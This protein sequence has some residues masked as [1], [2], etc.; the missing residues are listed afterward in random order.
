MADWSKLAGRVPAALG[1]VE[2]GLLRQQALGGV[3]Y[4]QAAGKESARVSGAIKQQ[5]QQIEALQLRYEQAATIA[6]DAN[7]ASLKS[8][9]SYNEKGEMISGSA[10]F[11]M[12]SRSMAQAQAAWNDLARIT[13]MEIKDTPADHAPTVNLII[14]SLEKTQ[15][16]RLSLLIKEAKSGKISGDARTTINNLTKN[17]SG[18]D[19]RKAVTD[20]LI[21][22]L[23]T[24]DPEQYKGDG[25]EGVGE[26]FTGRAATA[27]ILGFPF[28][29][30]Q[31][32]AELPGTL[33]GLGKSLWGGQGP[34]KQGYSLG[35]APLGYEDW[36]SLFGIPGAKPGGWLPDRA[37]QK[38]GIISAADAEARAKQRQGSS[39]L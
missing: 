11:E 14:S 3:M 23:K 31:D 8:P 9:P 25:L 38:E 1:A 35:Q 7:Q 13:G 17:I 29:M 28:E 32:I 2:E 16:G 37:P 24:M 22:R 20:A 5:E 27:S 33:Y 26:L 30:S 19:R 18:A 21:E 10:E 12:A 15:K 6:Q 39:G 36:R 4:E 34:Y